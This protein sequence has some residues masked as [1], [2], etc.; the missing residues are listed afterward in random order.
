MTAAA[1]LRLY[2]R[3][4]LAAQRARKAA[5]RAV[6]EAAGISTAQ[7][8]VLSVVAEGR[9]AGMP[10]NQRQVA[11]RLGVNESA[12]TAMVARLLKLGL[13]ERY[14]GTGARD[15]FLRLTPAG[16]LA[17]DRIRPAFATVNAVIEAQL[18]PDG[19]EAL[20]A[21]LDRLAEAFGEA[22]EG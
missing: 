3:L 9:D 16:D 19:A 6:A 11:A 2:H 15:W 1:R 13:L 17:R 7:A 20:A 12:V 4:Q 8:G 5:D 10:I 22:G 21:A 18:G 14:R